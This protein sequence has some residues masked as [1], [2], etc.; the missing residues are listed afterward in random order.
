MGPPLRRQ[1]PLDMAS[2]EN[3]PGH[4]VDLRQRLAAEELVID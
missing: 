4:F 3:K 2:L 1:R